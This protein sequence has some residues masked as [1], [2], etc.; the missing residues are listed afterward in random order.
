MFRFPPD[1][2]RPAVDANHLDSQALV[3][4]YERD[5]RNTVR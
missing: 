1:M 3:R 2:P 5:W 4:Y